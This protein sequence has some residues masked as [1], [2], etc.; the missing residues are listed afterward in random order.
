MTKSD[1]KPTNINIKYAHVHL[2]TLLYST[3][4]L[5]QF[6]ACI[7]SHVYLYILPFNLMTDIQLDN[8]YEQGAHVLLQ[9][10]A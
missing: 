7:F 2:H 8:P 1:I 4:H 10:L 3:L 6:F 5:N 9:C